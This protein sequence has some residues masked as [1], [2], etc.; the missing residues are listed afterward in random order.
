[1]AVNG[2]EYVRKWGRGEREIETAIKTE[3]ETE[4]EAEGKQPW[5]ESGKNKN[6][7]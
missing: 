3:I 5:E 6:T 4:I 7:H 2:T 1:M